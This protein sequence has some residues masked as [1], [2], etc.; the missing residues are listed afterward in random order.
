ME[1]RITDLL[2]R[3]R[4]MEQTRDIKSAI[5]RAENVRHQMQRTIACLDAIEKQYPTPTT[6]S[7]AK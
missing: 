1:K 4:A 5:N 7:R 2:A 3:L 6:R